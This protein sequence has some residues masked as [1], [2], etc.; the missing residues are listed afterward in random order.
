MSSFLQ[1]EKDIELNMIME[2]LDLARQIHLYKSSPDAVSKIFYE[3]P[4]A[5]NNARLPGMAGKDGK[6]YS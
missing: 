5:V 1:M 2:K 6:W 3:Q 4:V